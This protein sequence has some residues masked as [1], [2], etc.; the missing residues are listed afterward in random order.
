MTES[1]GEVADLAFD[2]VVARL[3]TV[4]ERLEAGQLGLEDALAAYEQGVHL[5]RRG[6]QLLEAAERKVEVL[7]S[8]A[9]GIATAPFQAKE[10]LPEEP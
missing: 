3:R 5:A 8:T 1:G 6:H 2:A 10:P 4:V 7:V 9:G